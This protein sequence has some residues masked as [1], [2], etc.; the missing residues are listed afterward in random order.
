MID[1]D[2]FCKCINCGDDL[3]IRL[4]DDGNMS[5]CGCGNFKS[6]FVQDMEDDVLYGGRVP[7]KFPMGLLPNM[8]ERY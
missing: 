7:N 5:Q 6:Q 8:R 3:T 1:G 2:Y 4:S